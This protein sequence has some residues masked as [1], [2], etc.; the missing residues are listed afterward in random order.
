MAQLANKVFD[1]PDAKVI[2]LSATPYKMYTMHHET[3]E[4]DHYGDF[5]RTI[6][7]LLNDD[8]ATSSFEKDLERFCMVCIP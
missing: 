7:F 6:R 1:Y 5:I 3:A 2:L 4:D 8:T